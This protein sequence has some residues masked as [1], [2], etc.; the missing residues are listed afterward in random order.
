MP[1]RF[2]APTFLLTHATS[3]LRTRDGAYVSLSLRVTWRPA[4]AAAFQRRFSTVTE[5][6]SS[7]VAMLD[8]QARQVTTL[9]PAGD[10]LPHQGLRPSEVPIGPAGERA[11]EL[12]RRRAAR[13]TA[14]D[15]I[16]L[17]ELEITGATPSVPPTTRPA[18]E[19][20]GGRE[21]ETP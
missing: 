21:D 12:L 3:P 13:A 5:A 1:F 8:E 16:R 15:A 10:L 4:D 9:F 19:P 7:V 20:E 18:E 17:I 11:V 2:D 14:D 6:E